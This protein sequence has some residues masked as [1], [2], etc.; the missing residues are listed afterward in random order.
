MALTSTTKT[1]TTTPA[2]ATQPLDGDDGP[3]WR[4][5]HS[6]SDKATCAQAACKRAGT[7]IAKGELRIGTQNWWDEEQKYYRQWLHW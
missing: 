1:T 3:K 5:E 4:V 6:V 2:A 7:K